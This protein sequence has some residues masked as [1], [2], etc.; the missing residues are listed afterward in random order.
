MEGAFGVDF[1]GVRVHQDTQADNLAESISARA[2]TTGS[3]IF[4]RRDEHDSN[5]TLMAHELAHVVQQSSGVQAASESGM[6]VGAAND[7]LE[8][9]ADRA[10]EL[11]SAGAGPARLENEA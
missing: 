1:S 3:D 8:L 4:L 5:T 7:P 2:F 9:E 10:A 6:S 11:V